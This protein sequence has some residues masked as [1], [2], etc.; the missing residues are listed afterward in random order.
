[1]TAPQQTP[2]FSDTPV[3]RR[4][5]ALAN[6]WTHW[7]TGWVG[8]EAGARRRAEIESDLWEQLADDRASHVVGTGVGAS[9]SWRVVAGMPADLAWM[10]H[11]RAIARGSSNREK[12]SMMNAVVRQVG[13]W[14]WVVL[15]LGIAAA[16][17]AI[18]AGNL[19][20]PGMPYMEGTV[21]AFACAALIV[22]GA[23]VRFKW[24]VVGGLL[25]VA[26]AGPAV[27][28]WWAPV[29]AV[30][31]VLVLLGAVIDLVILPAVQRRITGAGAAARVLAI[32]GVIVGTVAPVA[33]GVMPGLLV[34][35]V[36]VLALVVAAL[37]R[38]RQ[39]TL[40]AANDTV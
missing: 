15:A 17:V 19:A 35:V 30:I 25:V 8:D 33:T 6:G 21:F 31:G 34:T 12:E 5:V 27:L 7:Y 38:R 40:T 22:A 3:A 2:T 24:P 18:A 39:S 26:G 23:V 29:L 32:V 10:R 9:I 4:A 14:W 20:E 28:L 36:V 16:Y 11:Q 13:R 1:M 37:V